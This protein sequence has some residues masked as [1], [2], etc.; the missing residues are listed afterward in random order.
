MTKAAVRINPWTLGA[1]GVAAFATR[2]R[3]IHAHAQQR[4][5]AAWGYRG[6][7]SARTARA[8]RSAARRGSFGAAD[9]LRAIRARPL[10]H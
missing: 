3:D 4:G 7:M 8:K 6:R 2:V 9:V 10:G 1:I 5:G